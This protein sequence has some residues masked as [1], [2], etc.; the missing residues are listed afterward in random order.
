MVR[1]ALWSR[2]YGG[3]ELVDCI[4]CE[5]L[6]LDI[7]LL[8]HVITLQFYSAFY[9]PFPVLGYLIFFEVLRWGGTRPLY[10]CIWSQSYLP[11]AW[12]LCL[13]ICVSI[14]S[15]CSPPYLWRKF[16]HSDCTYA[17]LAPWWTWLCTLCTFFLSLVRYGSSNAAISWSFRAVLM[18]I[19]FLCN[20][21]SSACLRRMSFY[22]VV[23]VHVE[24]FAV[25]PRS[26]GR[27]KVVPETR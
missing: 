23:G 16:G 25:L 19:Y 22:S 18:V 15:R 14:I 11:L 24:T 7:Q 6:H 20:F 4:F 1:W 13:C 17:S 3:F 21:C 26:G 5:A 8:C 27:T 2:V 12:N 9:P 10:L